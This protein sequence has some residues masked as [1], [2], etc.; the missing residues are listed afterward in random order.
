MHTRE[1][2][3][4]YQADMGGPWLAIIAR[5]LD[6]NRPTRSWYYDKRDEPRLLAALWDEAGAYLGLSA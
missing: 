6:A 4:R 5:P 1:Q 3:G 2:A